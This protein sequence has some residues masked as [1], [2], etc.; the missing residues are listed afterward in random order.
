MDA[1]YSNTVKA[2]IREV[3]KTKGERKKSWGGRIQVKTSVNEQRKKSATSAKP[4]QIGRASI[5]S[6]KQREEKRGELGD[7]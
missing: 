7:G 5:S 3:K 1:E 2:G 4:V 6:N